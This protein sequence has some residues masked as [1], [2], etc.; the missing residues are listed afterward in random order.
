MSSRKRKA[1]QKQ[2]K[3]R[4]RGRTLKEMMDKGLITPDELEGGYVGGLTLSTNSSWWKK[5]DWSSP[6]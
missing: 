4:Y 2:I 5:M 1:L 3:Q 6:S